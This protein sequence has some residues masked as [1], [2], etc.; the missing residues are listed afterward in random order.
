MTE[1]PTSPMEAYYH[2]L[3]AEHRNKILASLSKANQ[4]I[5]QDKL[6]YIMA[7]VNMMIREKAKEDLGIFSKEEIDAVRE[8]LEKYGR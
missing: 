4:K 7:G 6:D 2:H 5:I 1:E 3:M 8:Y